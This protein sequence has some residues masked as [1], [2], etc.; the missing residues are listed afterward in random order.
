M[1]VKAHAT[2]APNTEIDCLSEFLTLSSRPRAPPLPTPSLPLRVCPCR[3]AAAGRLSVFPSIYRS[4]CLFVFVSVGIVCLLCSGLWRGPGDLCLQIK[5]GANPNLEDRV[6]L[7]AIH[8]AAQVLPRCR[9]RFNSLRYIPRRI[10][11]PLQCTSLRW[12]GSMPRADQ[13]KGSVVLV[14]EVAYVIGR[15]P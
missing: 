7:S 13:M 11:R 3:S 10:R 9:T 1:R 4:V 15:W 6:G 5:Y 14:F 2:I 12:R 8:R